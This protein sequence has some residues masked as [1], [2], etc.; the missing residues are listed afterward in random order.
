[1]TKATKITPLMKQYNDIKSKYPDTILLFRVGDFYETFGEDAILASKILGIVLTKRGAGSIS[2]TELAIMEM[3]VPEWVPS[4]EHHKPS[5]I[6]ALSEQYPNTN[7]IVTHTFIDSKDSQHPTITSNKF[8]DH[9]SNVLHA[10]DQYVINWDG[11]W[12]F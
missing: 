12:F 8:P 1:M 4:D 7:F 5:D 2:E 6:Q 10:Q 11:K 3:G 9:P